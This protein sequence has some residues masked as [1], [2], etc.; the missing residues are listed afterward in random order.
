MEDWRVLTAW[1]T[2]AGSSSCL[3]EWSPEVVKWSSV[4]MD[5][6]I[7][8]GDSVK[9]SDWMVTCGQLKWPVVKCLTGWSRVVKRSGQAVWLGSQQSAYIN[10]WHGRGDLP[11][12]V[13]NCRHNDHL[14]V[15]CFTSY[16]F[17]STSLVWLS[18]TSVYHKSYQT[19]L[20]L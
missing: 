11:Q 4:W 16:L 5:G 9:L 12:Y 1:W 19:A 2:A 15:I 13:I 10:I 18:L 14:L 6:R 20:W 7:W 17:Q 8:S 3:T